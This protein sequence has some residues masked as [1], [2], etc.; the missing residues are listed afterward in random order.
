M[1]CNKILKDQHFRIL[2]L[3]FDETD[4]NS[5]SFPLE[6]LTPQV[7]NYTDLNVIN[8]VKTAVN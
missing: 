7:I 2:V 6:D 4:K 8:Y 3:D 1:T 5:K